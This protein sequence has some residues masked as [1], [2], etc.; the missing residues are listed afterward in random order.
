MSLENLILEGVAL[1]AGELL[2][3]LVKPLKAG[4]TPQG[5]TRSESPGDEPRTYI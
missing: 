3:R 2:H 4:G 5:S 1:G